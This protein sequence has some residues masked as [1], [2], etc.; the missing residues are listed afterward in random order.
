MKEIRAGVSVRASK[1]CL[2]LR[3]LVEFTDFCECEEIIH[4][5]VVS[6]LDH[7][8]TILHW[9]PKSQLDQLQCVPN[10]AT[11]LLLLT[12]C[13]RRTFIGYETWRTLRHCKNVAPTIKTIFCSAMITI[14]TDA[15]ILDHIIHYIMTKYKSNGILQQISKTCGVRN[16]TGG[17]TSFKTQLQISCQGIF[18]HPPECLTACKIYS[19]RCLIL[20]ETSS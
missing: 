7:C 12:N 5:F 3:T 11:R 8:N 18:V 13:T 17:S 10:N 20:T 16:L 19:P 4:A 14:S 15:L 9:L 2:S 6:E 1:R